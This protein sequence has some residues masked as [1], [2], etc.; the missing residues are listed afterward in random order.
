[1]NAKI[2]HLLNKSCNEFPD[3]TFGQI[4]NKAVPEIKTEEISDTWI[5]EGL[6]FI[7]DAKCTACGTLK[8][9]DEKD[10]KTFS[11]WRWNGKNW[12]HCCIDGQIGHFDAF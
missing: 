4:L 11:K 1:M 2:L 7:L 3:L 12:Q 5:I 10:Y 9:E 8:S 6:T